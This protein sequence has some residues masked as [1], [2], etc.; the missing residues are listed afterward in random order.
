MISLC[1]LP[2]EPWGARLSQGHL[3]AGAVS[4]LPLDI[5]TPCPPE[6]LTIRLPSPP[7]LGTSLRKGSA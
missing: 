3:L 5:W 1:L 4:T 2:G 7:S 6:C